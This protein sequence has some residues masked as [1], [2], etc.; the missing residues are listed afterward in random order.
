MSSFKTLFYLLAFSSLTVMIQ[1]IVFIL[2]SGFYLL[3][4]LVFTAKHL[5]FVLKGATLIKLILLLTLLNVMHIDH[6]N[7]ALQGSSVA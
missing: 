2:C 1:I 4:F 3:S 6:L 7:M 5:N